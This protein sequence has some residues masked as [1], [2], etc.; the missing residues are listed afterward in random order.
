[1]KSYLRIVG[2]VH[3]ALPPLGGPGSVDVNLR[4]R[5]DATCNA[6]YSHCVNWLLSVG[7]EEISGRS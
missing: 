7:D 4:L 2:P 3:E 1:M 5:E 6:K